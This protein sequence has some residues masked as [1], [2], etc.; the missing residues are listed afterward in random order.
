MCAPYALSWGFPM[1]FEGNSTGNVAG[2]VGKED[3][4]C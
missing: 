3:L 4:L 2:N 1:N